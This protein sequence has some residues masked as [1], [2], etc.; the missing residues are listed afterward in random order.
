MSVGLFISNKFSFGCNGLNQYFS[1]RSI[2]DNLFFLCP[3]LQVYYLFK[4]AFRVL[5]GFLRF[6][7]AFNFMVWKFSF[8][9]QLL[10]HTRND[11][12][13]VDSQLGN[14]AYQSHQESTHTTN[15]RSK[16][17]ADKI[18]VSS[19]TQEQ[20]AICKPQ[21][22]RAQSNGQPAR[23]QPGRQEGTS[24]RHNPST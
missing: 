23:K 7:F 13:K 1:C 15:R 10:A 3:I 9:A 19:P 12:V 17:A 18:T 16:P 4:T 22:H 24:Q 14:K 5:S 21:A 11:V 2:F 6:L 8:K 20:S